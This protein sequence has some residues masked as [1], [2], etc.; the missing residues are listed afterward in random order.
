MERE[1]DEEESPP[2]RLARLQSNLQEYAELIV[3]PDP[4]TRPRKSP[5][6]RQTDNDE[7]QQMVDQTDSVPVPVVLSAVTGANRQPRGTAAMVKG[8]SQQDS[9]PLD[10]VRTMVQEKIF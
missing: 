9:F 4:R 8:L 7:N 10:P 6:L 2:G 5:T 1:Q 3:R